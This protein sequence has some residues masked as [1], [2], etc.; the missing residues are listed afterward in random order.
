MKHIILAAGIG[1]R[2]FPITLEIPKV[3]LGVGG[4]TLLANQLNISTRMQDINKIEVVCGFMAATIEDYLATHF[5][6]NPNIA[7]VINPDFRINNPIYSLRTAI[8]QI[9]TE[10]MLIT[11]GD[12]YY[13]Q[14]LVRHLLDSRSEGITMIISPYR[15]HTNRA[16]TVHVE[17]G[18]MVAIY[19]HAPE[20]NAYESPGIVVVKGEEARDVLYHSTE[21]LY[22]RHLGQPHYWHD[23]LNEAK[24]ELPIQIQVIG[25]EMWGEVDT[26]ND[27]TEVNELSRRIDEG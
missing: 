27:L 5:A 23:I 24:L 16:M 18:R 10:D 1:T 2:L 25:E 6:T 13:G 3:L 22:K 17:S 26:E 21:R 11:N 19:P 20:I 7:T 15:D 8:P 9:P 12:V 14:A 4:T